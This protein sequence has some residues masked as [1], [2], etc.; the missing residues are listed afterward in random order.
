M[1]SYTYAFGKVPRLFVT[2][3]AMPWPIARRFAAHLIVL[4]APRALPSAGNNTEIN[5]AMMPMT[6]SNSTRVN[7]RILF[8]DMCVLLP[9]DAVLKGAAEPSSRAA[10]LNAGLFEQDVASAKVGLALM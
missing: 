9:S 5:T 1:P 4:A 3:T 2:Y 10:E 7:A 6:T 8:R